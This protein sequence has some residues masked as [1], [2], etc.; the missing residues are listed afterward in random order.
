MRPSDASVR[1]EAHRLKFIHNGRRGHLLPF[2]ELN[3]NEKQFF[4]EELTR[5]VSARRLKVDHEA[6]E[7]LF[8]VMLL[9]ILN[10]WGIM[11]PHPRTSV[12]ETAHGYSCQTCGC[13]IIT[14]RRSRTNTKVGR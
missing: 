12:Q 2:H 5:D 6:D 3:E 8:D 1:L 9:N 13:D 14:A 10:D 7:R 4:I 11:C